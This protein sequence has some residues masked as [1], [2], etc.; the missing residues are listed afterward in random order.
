MLT[1]VVNMSIKIQPPF[2]LHRALVPVVNDSRTNAD[3]SI[4]VLTYIYSPC[5]FIQSDHKFC[6]KLSYC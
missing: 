2:L 6:N 3:I 5:M 1:D 4:L